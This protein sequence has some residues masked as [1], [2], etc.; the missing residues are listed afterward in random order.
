MGT[1]VLMGTINAHHVP[2]ML[3]VCKKESTTEQEI[4]ACQ[5]V[6][7][8]TNYRNPED[9]PFFREQKNPP[10]PNKKP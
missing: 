5:Q 4:A 3:A 1:D 7:Q 8:V 10:K 6:N 2:E 9:T